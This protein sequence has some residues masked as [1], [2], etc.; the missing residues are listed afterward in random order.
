MVQDSRRYGREVK[1]S[2]IEFDSEL[3]RGFAAYEDKLGDWWL[4]RARDPSHSHAYRKIA[5]YLRA[6]LKRPPR[7]VV[8]YACGP[9]DLLARLS[10]IFP[11]SRLVGLDGS[12]Y[13]LGLARRRL[14]HLQHESARRTTLIQ[15]PLPCFDLPAMEAD[16]A[17]L[18]FPN[19]L[20]I[21]EAR[22]RRRLPKC[23][24]LRQTK[25]GPSEL[26]IARSLSRSTDAGAR[27]P[28]DDPETIHS[29]LLQARLVSLNLRGLLKRGGLCV[30]VEYGRA[31]RHELSEIDMLRISF[32]EGSLDM[33]VDGKLPRQWFRMLASSYCGSRVIED[34]DQQAG[35]RNG[36]PGGYLITVLRAV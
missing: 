14:A 29:F 25:L 10:A 6:S 15:T 9:G 19:M 2:G 32:E 20:Q 8:D 35:K 23:G 26:A 21:V 13:L 27:D 11:D 31:Q 16:L 17:L 5:E 33:R 28:D 34:V 22:G 36:G 30:R 4:S 12:N 3:S 7:L 1:L 18:V 24:S